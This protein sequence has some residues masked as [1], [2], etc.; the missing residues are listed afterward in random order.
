M[1]KN[2]LATALASGVPTAIHWL[3]VDIAKMSPV[4]ESGVGL[5]RPLFLEINGVVIVW[6]CNH[7]AD[8]PVLS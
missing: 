6:R 5:Y 3:S 1:P 2:L 7:G 4:N 8:S